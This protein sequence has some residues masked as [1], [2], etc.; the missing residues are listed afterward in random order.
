MAITSKP[1]LRV[2]AF[3]LFPYH[4]L[5]RASFFVTS[6]T[7]KYE[8][9]TKS[10]NVLFTL[11]GQMKQN[12]MGSY[13]IM[14]RRRCVAKFQSSAQAFAKM[15]TCEHLKYAQT[16]ALQQL[17]KQFQNLTNH[18]IPMFRYHTCKIKNS[19]RVTKVLR[20]VLCARFYTQGVIRRVLYV[21]C[22]T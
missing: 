19:Y 17:G 21:G 2:R 4:R 20:R 6:N 7:C 15:G 10:T 18:S 22:Y 3:R 11:C 13:Q 8:L 16:S 9:R 12:R 1:F 14:K 5:Y